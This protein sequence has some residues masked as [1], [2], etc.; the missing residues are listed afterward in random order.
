MATDEQLREE[1]ARLVAD[2]ARPAALHDIPDVQKRLGVGRSTVFA[3]MRNGTLRSVKVGRRR[4]I[5]EQS[6]VDFIN[7][8]TETGST[9]GQ[10]PARPA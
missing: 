8:V 2:A 1:V 5:P 6:I 10:R 3:L 4:L 9:A 7:N